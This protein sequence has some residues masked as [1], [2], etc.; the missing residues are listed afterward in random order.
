MIH[1]YQVFNIDQSHILRQ[2]LYLYRIMKSFHKFAFNGFL[3]ESGSMGLF[4]PTTTSNFFMDPTF[5]EVL[6]VEGKATHE[7]GCSQFLSFEAWHNIYFSP[8]SFLS[9]PLFRAKF[10]PIRCA[11]LASSQTWPSPCS[12]HSPGRQR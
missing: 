4:F 2:S 9:F 6:V 8:R 11:P 5:S 12:S 7:F 1:K 3:D 10:S